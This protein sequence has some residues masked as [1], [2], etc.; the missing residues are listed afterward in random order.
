[1]KLIIRICVMTYISAFTINEL[2]NPYFFQ[3]EICSYN[4]EPTMTIEGE[5]VNVTCNCYDDY[6]TID[7]DKKINGVK[8]Q[9]NYERRRRFIALFLSVF[10]PLGIDYLYLR[11]SWAFV[12]ILL[13]SLI[14]CVGNCYL[15]VESQSEKNKNKED[16]MHSNNQ[17]EET[18][19]IARIIF[20]VL[21]GI[22]F[23]FYV[24]NIVLIATGVIKDGNGISTI[25]DLSYLFKLYY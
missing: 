4:G 6:A 9:C 8:V 2:N 20:L 17:D 11:N 21:G 14:V 7:E 1:M 25:N 22:L 23:V 15:L 12:L 18:F 19:T 16:K 5:N 10:I 3:K 24:T 13:S